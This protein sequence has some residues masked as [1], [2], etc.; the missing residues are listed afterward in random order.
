MFAHGHTASMKT[1]L[2]DLEVAGRSAVRLSYSPPTLAPLQQVRVVD[3]FPW[4]GPV[5]DFNGK[6]AK[7]IGMEARFAALSDIK[8]GNDHW[9]YKLEIDGGGYPPIWLPSSA[10]QAL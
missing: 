5:F 7:V 3:E 4:G 2:S 9:D 6:T 10:I 8:Y 1:D